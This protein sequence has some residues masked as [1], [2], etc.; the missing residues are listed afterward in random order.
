M[1][2]L[3]VVLALPF[4]FAFPVL[5]F[6]LEQLELTPTWSKTLKW[7]G[8][9]GVEE[10]G[11]CTVLKSGDLVQVLAPSGTVL[12]SWPYRKVSKY[13]EPIQVG[14][15]PSCDAI[16]IPGNAGYKYTWIVPRRGNSV[17]ART[18]SVP[19]DATFDRTGKFVAV[20]THA[21]TVYLY[22]RDGALKWKQDVDGA[23]IASNLE[24][25]ED[26]TRIVLRGWAGAGIIGIDGRPEWASLA[27]RFRVARDLQTF[28]FSHEPNHGPGLPRITVTDAQRETLWHRWAAIEAFIS[29]NGQRILAHIDIDQEKEER[30][31]TGELQPGELQLLSRSSEVIRSFPNHGLPIALS[32]DVR[33]IWA[34]S[35]M[36]FD[37]LNDRGEV[38]A[39]ITAERDATA[40]GRPHY[41]QRVMV[42]RDFEQ[43]VV[44]AEAGGVETLAR[45]EVPARCRPAG[46]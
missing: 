25:S 12:W 42:S 16:A 1:R 8:L 13:I 38:L 19:A 33:R 36:G 6:S 5:A 2:L 10:H 26:N 22:S 30:D 32:A 43:V 39:R 35:E 27:N 31:L 17:A 41:Y 18:M 44:S 7:P 45:Y 15:S 23:A 3:Q 20:G 40:S 4:L 28:V 9:V 24:F 21:G 14:V 46:R 37:C 29:A 34:Q 11:R